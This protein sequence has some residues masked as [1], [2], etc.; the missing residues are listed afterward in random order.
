MIYKLYIKIYY[1]N[2]KNKVN[3]TID[4][5]VIIVKKL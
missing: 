2:L 3:F 4:K 1:S 5:F